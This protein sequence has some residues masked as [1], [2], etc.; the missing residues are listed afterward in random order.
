MKTLQTIIFLLFFSS[1]FG[2]TKTFHNIV[3]S[4]GDTT[5]W[6]SY[7]CHILKK[8]SLIPLETS[9]Q[10][11]YFRVWT[12]KQAIDIWQNQS[13]TFSG[14]ITNWTAECVP[15]KEK[16]TNRVYVLTKPL[17]AD[18]ATLI[19]QLYI[20]S[21]ILNLPTEDSIKDWQQGLDGVMYFI[22]HS[23]TD[24]YSFKSYWTP[25]AQGK[26]I[27]AIQVQN[28]IDNAFKLANAQTV[29]KLFS[30]QIP[31]ECYMNGGPSVTMKILTKKEKKKYAKE[32]KNY[33]Q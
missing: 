9:A 7:H 11:E 1:I 30:K 4:K 5:Y 26:L 29:W 31:Y 17:N 15:E 23:T 24:N 16:E 20:S 19:R 18:T 14:T 28:F 27:E 32:R 8:L 22:E 13:G 10:K 3:S 6:Y 2:Q 12:N 33:C 25:Q 21:G